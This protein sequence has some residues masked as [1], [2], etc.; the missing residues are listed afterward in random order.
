VSAISPQVR[1]ATLFVA[2]AIASTLFIR[3]D[4]AASGFADFYQVV[5]ESL[6]QAAAAIEEDGNPGAVA[7]R[8]D[9]RGW[10][11]GWWFEA[12]LH[13]PVFVGSD[14]RWLAFPDEWRHAR[15]AGTLFEGGLDAEEFHQRTTAAGVR[16]LVVTK[17]DWIGWERWLEL[18]NFP[19][20]TIYDD[21]RYL[22]LRVT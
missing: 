15:L 1:G 6:V 14:P 12:L 21:D 7:V 11:I 5:N 10:P 19:I 4:R 16:Y 18:P 3:A 9:R 2:L 17:W 20:T 8:E 22:V 13:Q